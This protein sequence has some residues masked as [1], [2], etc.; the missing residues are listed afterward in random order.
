MFRRTRFASLLAIYGVLVIGCH[1]NGAGGP[2]TGGRSGAA[3]GGPAVTV[4]LGKA[5][6]RDTPIYLD[7]IGTVFAFNTVTVRTQIDGQLQRVEFREGQDVK[8]GDLLAVVDPRPYRAALDQAKA[9]KAEDLAQ[10]AS[11]TVTY[12]RNYS[13]GQKGLVG[14]Q[15]IDTQKAQEDQMKAMVQADDAAIEQTAVQLGYTDIKAPFDGRVGLRQI[16]IGNIIHASDAN[17]I[18]VLTQLKPIS[19]IF[20]LPQQNWPEV[21]RLM[22]QGS[23][24]NVEAFGNDTHSLGTGVLS[25]ADNQ[26]DATTGTIRLKATFPN[27]TLSLWPGQFVNVRLLVETRKAAVVV[28]SSVV[29]RGPQGTYAF[30]V[31]AEAIVDMRP[32]QVGQID[33]GWAVIEEGLKDGETVVVDGQ[34]KLQSGSAVVAATA[35]GSSGAAPKGGGAKKTPK[36]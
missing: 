18:V 3:R 34:Y 7:G 36:S 11:A 16:D 13:L 20:T 32:L 15:T 17:G 1:R 12:T 24:L 28:P 29:Q 19:V 35:A 9:K 31:N 2:P 22:A 33:G 6:R 30:V 23:V 21:Q 8:A 27:T 26:I 4:V 25:V 14:Q 5:Q 10:L